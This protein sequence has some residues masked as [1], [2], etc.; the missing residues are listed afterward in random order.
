M[1]DEGGRRT[2]STRSKPLQET[3]ATPRASRRTRKNIE[4]E[5]QHND[6]MVIESKLDN[7]AEDIQETPMET[8]EIDGEDFYQQHSEMPQTN[9]DNGSSNYCYDDNLTYEQQSNEKEETNQTD[10]TTEQETFIAD[11]A[12]L[13]NANSFPSGIDENSMNKAQLE[14]DSNQMKEFIEDEMN[15][16]SNDKSLCEDTFAQSEETKPGDHATDLDAENISEDELPGPTKAKVEDAE[17]V[18]DEELPGPKTAENLNIYNENISED[19]LPGPEKAKVEDA[20]E[21]SDEELPGPKMAELPADTEVVSEDELPVLKRDIKRKHEDYD[22]NEPTDEAEEKKVKTNVDEKPKYKLPD[23]EKYWK[24]VKADREDFNAWTYLLQYV[25]SENDPEAAREAYDSFLSRYCYC[26]GYWRKYADYEKKKGS[27]EKCEE[28]FERGL[29]A[30]PLSIDLWIHYLTHV[31]QKHEGDRDFIRSQFERALN[32]CG[33][34]FRS[35][36]LWD[37]YIKWE[38]E[39]KNF[40]NIMNIYDRLLSTPTQGYK[41]HWDNFRE[42]VNNNNPVHKLVSVEEFKILRDEV[43]KEL[44]EANVGDIDDLAPGEDEPNDHV[45]SEEEA[46][47]IR[48]LIINKRKKINKATVEMI[49]KRWTFEEGIKRPYFHVK[50]L[51]RIQLKNWK[52]YLDFEIEQGDE[53]RIL[54]LFERCLIACAL[55]EEFWLKLIRYL[56]TQGDSSKIEAQKR[57]VFVRACTIHHPDKPSLLMMWAA[58]EESHS[59]IKKASEILENLDKI[60]PNLLQVAY[61]RINLERRH[62]NLKKSTQLYEHYIIMSKNKNITASLVIKYARFL[63]KIL[64]DYDEAMKCLKGALDKDPLN[65]RI[66]LQII[67]LALQRNNVDEKEILGILDDFMKQ[68]SLEL[69]Q[70]LLFAQRKVEFLEDFGSSVIALQDA[71]KSLQVILEKTKESKKKSSDHESNVVKKSKETP[72]SNNGNPYSS[73]PYN[74]SSSS[75]HYSSSSYPNYASSGQYDWN[76]QSYYQQ[77]AYGYA[78]HLGH[79]YSSVIADTINRF[80]KLTSTNNLN[81]FST[82]TDEHGMKVLQ[83]ASKKGIPIDEYCKNISEDY[84]KLFQASQVEFTDFIRTTEER[85]KQA[86]WKFWNVLSS[87]NAIYKDTYSGWYCVQDETFLTESQL[88]LK[89]SVKVSL[90]SGHPVEWTE[91]ENYMFKLSD[92]QD[93]VIYWAKQGNHIDPPV[94]NKILL[95]MLQEELPDI[96]ISRP[97]SRMSWGITVPNDPS[98]KIY[99]WLDALTNYLTVAGY[100]NELKVWPPNIHVIGKDILKFHGIYWPAFLIAAGLEPPKKLLVHS[101]WTVDGQKM[102]KSK[103]NVVN[104]T[105]R[106]EIYTMEGIR[107]FLLREGVPYNDGNYSDTKVVRTLNSELADTFGNLLSRACAK[108]LN[109]QQIFP[110]IHNDQLNDIVKMDS[111]K[112]LIEK[113]AELPE[114][115]LENFICFNFHYIVDSVMTTLHSANNFFESSKPWE[116][117]NGSANDKRKLETIISLTME[118]L[119]ICGIVLQPIIPNFTERLLKR[120][121]IPQ[122]QRLWRDTKLYLRKVSHPLVDLDSNILFKRIILESEKKEKQGNK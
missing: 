120:L 75:G 116:F 77:G 101:H 19:E 18:S 63:N 93:D 17:E 113:I 10:E 9:D 13:E 80:E 118:S 112:I 103:Q 22:P 92:Y 55:Y 68:E 7:S 89:N 14:S 29:K 117:K 60:H 65:T 38:G 69:D 21:V 100:P 119:R 12:D 42:L 90:E 37:G 33:L 56:E 107:Y 6:E 84:K 109:P 108:S 111:C 25:D 50:Q 87:Q 71:Q 58:F 32:A 98:Q 114:K 4:E 49:N 96:S 94:F 2:R 1:A 62:G 95:D 79:L 36:K 27:P 23:L 57:D 88:E 30:I 106:S 74:Y 82:G 115:C 15:D 78:P 99:V 48:K 102:S 122:E 59:N 73:T 40:H 61:F 104:P 86:V 11:L 67:D 97:S 26:Y 34:E 46:D 31:K 41:T 44:G 105:E 20:E 121:N 85:H 28:V 47:A 70:K 54:V 81:I 91:E 3:P 51:E 64:N 83:A 8:N 24:A 5:E 52:E 43:R 39:E 72:S 45:R 110:Q 16:R 76:Q 66:A 35:D 53:K